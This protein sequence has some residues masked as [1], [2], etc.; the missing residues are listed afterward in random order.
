MNTRL[1]TDWYSLY[2]TAATP[3]IQNLP[4]YSTVGNHDLPTP[5]GVDTEIA[6]DRLGNNANQPYYPYGQNWNMPA[7]YYSLDYYNPN[8]ART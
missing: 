6:Y 7:R 3:A 8:T 4:W 2:Q 1:Y 5:G